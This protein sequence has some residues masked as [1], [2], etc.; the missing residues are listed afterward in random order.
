LAS[1]FD[2]VRVGFEAFAF[3]ALVAAADLREMT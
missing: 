3:V 2:L 1:M